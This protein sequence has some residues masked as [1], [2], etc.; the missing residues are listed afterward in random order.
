[1]YVCICNA[2]TEDEIRAVAQTGV[3][4]LWTLQ[5]ELGVAA[6]CGTCKE[7]AMQVLRDAEQ[8]HAARMP[9]EPRM[10]SPSAA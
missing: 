9:A 4:D 1:M 7:S 10:Y 3:R 5:K 8:P 6:G 2:I